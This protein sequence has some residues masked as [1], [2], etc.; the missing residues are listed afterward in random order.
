MWAAVGSSG[1][2]P[3]CNYATSLGVTGSPLSHQLVSA[4]N[5]EWDNISH[6]DPSPACAAPVEPEM[7]GIFLLPAQF[8]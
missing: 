4:I 2:H 7:N 6:G 3:L 5:L 8:D 1:V